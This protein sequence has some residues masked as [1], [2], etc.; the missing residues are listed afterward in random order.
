MPSVETRI[1]KTE[2]VEL[3]LGKVDD[4]AKIVRRYF[5]ESNL[6]NRDEVLFSGRKAATAAQRSRLTNRLRRIAIP[7]TRFGAVAYDKDARRWESVAELE[8]TA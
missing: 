1:G 4:G 7:G 3:L 2:A 6:S 8:I 5:D